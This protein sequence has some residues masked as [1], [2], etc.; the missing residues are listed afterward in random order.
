MSKSN[1][2]E[3]LGKPV[4]QMTGEEFMQLAR[5]AISSDSANGTDSTRYVYGVNELSTQIGCCASTIFDLKRKG[6]LDDA[7]VSRVGRKI[8]FDVERARVLA[9]AYQR[10]QRENRN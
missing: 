7:I 4:W 3:L 9:D 1:P 10:E 6:V 8:V 2:T 5:M